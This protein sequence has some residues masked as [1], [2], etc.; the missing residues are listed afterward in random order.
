MGGRAASPFPHS[1]RGLS[2]P[3]ASRPAYVRGPFGLAALGFVFGASSPM[4]ALAEA[5]QLKPQAQK[6]PQ[7]KSAQLA[8]P[9][10]HAPQGQQA[11]TGPT[12]VQARLKQ[13]A[14][15]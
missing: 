2:M 10:H 3:F 1:S 12:S 5:Q 9:A 15:V 7:P 6:K 4:L 13:W 11:S 14:S 8:Q